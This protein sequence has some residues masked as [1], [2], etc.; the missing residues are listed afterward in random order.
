MMFFSWTSVWPE[1]RMEQQRLK[2][3]TA[4]DEWERN[5]RTLRLLESRVSRHANRKRSFCTWIMFGQSKSSFCQCTCLFS[6]EL[7]RFYSV[8]NPKSVITWMTKDSNVRKKGNNG[9]RSLSFQFCVLDLMHVCGSINNCSSHHLSAFFYFNVFVMTMTIVIT[10]REEKKS[11]RVRWPLDT[12]MD[13]ANDYVLSSLGFCILGS[14]FPTLHSQT[15]PPS[16]LFGLS[17]A[18]RPFIQR[19]THQYRNNCPTVS[20]EWESWET[21][22][23]R[24]WQPLNGF[25]SLFP[26]PH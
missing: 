6:L 5:K 15:S 25:V 11:E 13:R 8:L 1:I 4:K 23:D 22:R 20:W 24:C 3:F 14:G 12:E 17:R 9:R 26:H 2:M 19:D 21:T 7:K 16:H 18:C 10:M